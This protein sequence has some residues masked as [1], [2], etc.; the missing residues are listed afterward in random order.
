M[1]FSIVPLWEIS[2]A[3]IYF[4]QYILKLSFSIEYGVDY[5]QT[6]NFLCKKCLEMQSPVSTASSVISKQK[7]TPWFQS[8]KRSIPTERPP[9][10]GEIS[11]NFSG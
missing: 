5:K 7:E 2:W 3:T 6:L 11:A 1:Y 4:I 10:V 9:F 8:R